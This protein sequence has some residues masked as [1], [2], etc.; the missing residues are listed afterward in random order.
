MRR[1]VLMVAAACAALLMPAANAFA[2]TGSPCTNGRVALVNAQRILASIPAYVQAESLIAKEVDAYKTE[3]A[4]QQGSFDSARVAYS[5]K[6]TLLTASQKAAE[7]KK[8][9]DQNDNLQKHAADLD[10]KV[11][12][13]NAELLQPL[14]TRV[15]EMLDGV[16]AELNCA[17]IFDVSS[18]TGIAS[19]DKSL[20]L[21]DRVID[22][23]KAADPAAKPPAKPVTSGGIKPPGGGGEPPAATTPTTP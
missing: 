10:A 7:V 4:K 12:Q 6:A 9:Q 20:D 17:I 11:N 16:R 19:A 15:Q 23:L 2:Q 1:D 21:T 8:L 18:G 5:E 22:R 14:Q 13:R 3:L